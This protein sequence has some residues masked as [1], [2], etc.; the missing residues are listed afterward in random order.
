LKCLGNGKD[1]TSV[2]GVSYKEN[3]NI[4]QNAN[5]PP[6]KDYENLK[7]ALR[8]AV[9]M[10][11]YNRETYFPTKYPADM[12]ISSRGCPYD[13]SF[14][15]SKYFWERRYGA[16][17]VEDVIDEIKHMMAKY[18]TKTIHFREDLFTARKDRVLVFCEKLKELEIDWTCQSRVNLIDE[19]LLRVMKKSG[20]KGISFG[21][22]SANEHT[23]KFLN[24]GTT[25]QDNIIAIDLC[26]K[27]G[28]NW[29]GGF[30]AGVINENKEDIINTFNFMKKVSSYKH[31]FVPKGVA[32]FLGFPVSAT[33]F[34]L[35]KEDLVAY[36]WLDGELLIPLGQD[37]LGQF[38]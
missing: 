10:N 18:G 11:D 4:I 28:M 32:R 38:S 15:S 31:S 27:V 5:R 33:Y 25:V 35:L 1:L 37:I 21:F 29:T 7:Y 3:G 16:R 13:C 9:D 2:L 36:D 22:E 23:L 26:E 30:M 34:Q 12:V 19:S 14:C 24:K 20:C 8:E 17:G 6:I